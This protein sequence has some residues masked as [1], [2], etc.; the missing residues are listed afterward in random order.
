ML[1]FG[2]PLLLLLGLVLALILFLMFVLYLFLV[3]SQW[4]YNVFQHVRITKLIVG[5]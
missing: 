2:T 3:T 4:R 5:G 1:A